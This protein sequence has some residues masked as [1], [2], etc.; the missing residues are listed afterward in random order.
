MLIEVVGLRG[1]GRASIFA[2]AEEAKV[3]VK[4][5]YTMTVVVGCQL[6]RLAHTK[7]DMRRALNHP[8]CSHGKRPHARNLDGHGEKFKT[9]VRQSAEITEVLDNR[10]TGFQEI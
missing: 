6:L 8:E 10:H 1:A 9:L 7:D 4:R 2:P 5:E 3:W